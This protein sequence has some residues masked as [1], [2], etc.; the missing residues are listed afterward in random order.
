MKANGIT[1]KVFSSLFE[2]HQS[3]KSVHVHILWAWPYRRPRPKLHPQNNEVFIIVNHAV[4]LA[5][6]TLGYVH[7]PRSSVE[8]QRQ[9]E[10]SAR[11]MCCLSNELTDV[12]INKNNEQDTTLF[13]V[14]LRKRATLLA[15]LSPLNMQTIC[16]DFSQL[17]EAGQ[18]EPFP[19]QPEIGSGWL[20]PGYGP[21]TS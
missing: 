18:P 17:R 14:S 3:L 15:Q 13:R 16:P 6:F 4:A 7:M 9:V 8:I 2:Q 1:V 19:G 11:D 5:L 21:E 10:P 12:Y 20:M